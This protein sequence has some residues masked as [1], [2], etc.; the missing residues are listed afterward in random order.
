MQIVIAVVFYNTT[1]EV[2]TL[3]LYIFSIVVTTQ[4]NFYCLFF[5]FFDSAKNEKL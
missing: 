1:E 3:L 5:E 4:W 2:I